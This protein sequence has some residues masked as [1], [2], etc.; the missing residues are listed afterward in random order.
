MVIMK[1]IYEKLL[2]IH[3]V[4]VLP[5]CTNYVSDTFTNVCG[6]DGS[7]FSSMNRTVQVKS[8]IQCARE[9]IHVAPTIGGVC[10]GINVCVES[11]DPTCELL[12]TL[13]NGTDK[14]Y[15]VSRAG[16]MFYSRK[17]GNI[18]CKDN[19]DTGNSTD[20]TSGVGNGATDNT[21][22]D[23]SVDPTSYPGDVTIDHTATESSSDLT[24]LRDITTVETTHTNQTNEDSSWPKGTYTLLQPSTGCPN[25]WSTG[26]IQFEMQAGGNS[27]H[28]SNYLKGDVI[29]NLVQW[30]FCTKTSDVG[31]DEW[32]SGR[33]CVMRHGGN[34][35]SDFWEGLISFDE[36]DSGNHADRTRNGTLPDLY[37]TRDVALHFCCKNDATDAGS[38][39]TLPISDPFYLFPFFD[40]VCPNVRGMNSSREHTYFDCENTYNQNFVSGATP[41]SIISNNHQISFCYYH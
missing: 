15:E 1:I 7:V 21:V 11:G 19:T 38:E 40:G 33:Y 37:T 4:L 30:Y 17:K 14:L 6:E 24:I 12:F 5:A 34:C 39:M 35:P 29:S 16:C 23:S 13:L 22:T 18:T 28:S 26:Y 20:P 3:A 41:L 31:L 9:C 25:G 8:A 2:V 36:E 10:D 32:P 27:Y